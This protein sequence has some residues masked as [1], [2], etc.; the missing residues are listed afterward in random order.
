MQLIEGNEDSLDRGDIVFLLKA[1]DKN[2]FP[3]V[4]GRAQYAGKGGFADAGV[5]EEVYHRTVRQLG[6]SKNYLLG[7]YADPSLK[8]K[9]AF[10]ESNETKEMK[11]V[12]FS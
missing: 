1:L 7:L 9:L 5:C 2:G 11:V 6:N 12:I 3:V 4:V 10:I 8:V